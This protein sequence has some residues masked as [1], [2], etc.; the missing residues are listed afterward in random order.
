MCIKLVL[1]GSL[2]SSRCQTSQK[3]NTIDDDNAVD[4]LSS[5]CGRRRLLGPQR[6]PRTSPSSRRSSPRSSVPGARPV[7]AAGRTWRRRSARGRWPAWSCAR[8]SP[9]RRDAPCRCACA[10]PTSCPVCPTRGRIGGAGGGWR[11]VARRR[12]A[13]GGARRLSLSSFCRRGSRIS[14]G[15]ASPVGDAVGRHKRHRR[16]RTDERSKSLTGYGQGAI[17]GRTQGASGRDLVA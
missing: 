3:R 14:W 7:A 11:V 2:W 9:R 12:G 1:V 15:R 17:R 13:G 6:R 8:A 16:E 4:L 5:R 10:G